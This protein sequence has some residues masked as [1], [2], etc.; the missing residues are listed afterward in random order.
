MKLMMVL[1]VRDE[2]DILEANL[3]YHLS[4][5]VDFVI[6]MDHDS[7]D[8]TR[9][10]LEGYA[11][12]GHLHLI[13]ESSEEFMQ[14]RWLTR[15]ARMAA[16][17]FGADWII[18]NDADEFWW[19]AAGTLKDVLDAVPS[20]FGVVS[21]SRPRFVP[22]PDGVGSFAKRLVVREVQ[23]SAWGKV[24][25]R[26]LPNL[27]VPFGSHWV[28]LEGTDSTWARHDPS[29][30]LREAPY[31]PI[32]VFHFPLRSSAQFEKKVKKRLRTRRKER[33]GWLT[34]QF[35]KDRTSDLH[36][37]YR[38]GWLRE[39]YN[40]EL[41]VDDDAVQ[42]GI[43]EG[44]LTIDRRFERL[45]AAGSEASLETSG[46]HVTRSEAARPVLSGPAVAFTWG[47]AEATEIQMEMMSSLA[48][49]FRYTLAKE[50]RRRKKAERRLV[51]LE[52]TRWWRL[53]TRLSRLLQPVVS[54]MRR[55]RAQRRTSARAK[56]P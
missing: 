36:R 27:S 34:G 31:W 17:E 9:G 12:E 13:R 18:S 56:K 48:G 24:T 45:F 3:D 37:A 43:E 49:R 1:V 26:A 22:R 39:F 29:S 32:R 35:P 54:P 7:E 19:P 8:G 41:V 55:I 14:D 42:A 40:R 53:G 6:A 25:Y 5:G 10:I 28:D 16:T 47:E 50:Q 23:A 21:A 30:P 2:D 11:R 44:R 15:M 33:I 20:Q 4:Q 38:E 51:D 46:A 52:A